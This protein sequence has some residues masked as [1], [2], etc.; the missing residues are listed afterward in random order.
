MYNNDVNTCFRCVRIN[1]NDVTSIINV[2]YVFN[3]VIISSTGRY[4]A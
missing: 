1:I 4:V 2:I 3:V